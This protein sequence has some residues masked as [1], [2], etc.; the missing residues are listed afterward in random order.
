M[1]SQPIIAPKLPNPA[2]PDGLDPASRPSCLL[3]G[4]RG[5][6]RP[7]SR[8]MM[9]HPH[10]SRSSTSPPKKAGSTGRPLGQRA[11]QTLSSPAPAAAAA[12]TP[13]TWREPLK[14]H[15]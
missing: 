8:M 7:S 11:W 9:S 12:G 10:P 4:C 5:A 6:A 2:P 13:G 1:A 14:V 15:P 3:L